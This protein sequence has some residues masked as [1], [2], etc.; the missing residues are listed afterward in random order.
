MK[1]KVAPPCA[2]PWVQI[3]VKYALNYHQG[4]LRLPKH[5]FQT[6]SFDLLSGFL[7]CFSEKKISICGKTDKMLRFGRSNRFLK[8][9]KLSFSGRNQAPN[10][11]VLAAL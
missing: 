6:A 9:A 7:D 2:K 10:F 3:A 11:D 5:A 1:K 4:L 8:V